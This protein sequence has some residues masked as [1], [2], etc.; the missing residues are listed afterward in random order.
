MVWSQ[1][2]ETG[3]NFLPDIPV[4]KRGDEVEALRRRIRELERMVLK[5][6][7]RVQELTES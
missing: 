6:Q 3:V 7:N 4:E 2:D 1:G 5:L